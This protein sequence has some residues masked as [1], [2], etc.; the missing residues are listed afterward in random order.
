MPDP[1]SL[2]SMALFLGRFA[3]IAYAAIATILT[4]ACLALQTVTAFDRRLARR[5]PFRS[6]RLRAARRSLFVQLEPET[7]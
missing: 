2:L 5:L 6:A 4:T 1:S 3:V 7:E